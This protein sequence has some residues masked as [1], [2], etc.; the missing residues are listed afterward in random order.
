MKR[1]VTLLLLAT[2]A[3]TGCSSAAEPQANLRDSIPSDFTDSGEGIAWKAGEIY[4]STNQDPDACNSFG[5]GWMCLDIE[6]FA[7]ENCDSVAPVGTVNDIFT[8]EVIYDSLPK[9][10]IKVKAGE[11][12]TFIVSNNNKNKPEFGEG[13]W[14]VNGLTCN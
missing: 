14:V 6:Y 7:Y 13:Y 1:L 2:F 11:S 3:L 10:S 5:S 9:D 12:G 8:E 4:Y